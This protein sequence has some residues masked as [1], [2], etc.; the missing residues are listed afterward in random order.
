MKA[1]AVTYAAPDGACSGEA[2]VNGM[3]GEYGG[4]HALFPVN[5]PPST[6]NNKKAP[7]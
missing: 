7:I 2:D 6:S 4:L 5:P 3:R 1:P